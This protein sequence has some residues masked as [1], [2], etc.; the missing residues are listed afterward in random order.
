MNS[1]PKYPHITVRLIGE[2]GNTLSIMGRISS[3]LRK[4]GVSSKDIAAFQSE[5]LSGD[6]DH[7]L[8]TAMKWVSVS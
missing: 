1:A 4:D 8:Q 7:A 2:D 3:A 5:I 6:Y